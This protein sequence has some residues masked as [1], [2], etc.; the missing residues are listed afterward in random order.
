[1]KRIAVIS[2]TLLHFQQRF[3]DTNK[4]RTCYVEKNEFELLSSLNVLLTDNAKEKSFQCV[5]SFLSPAELFSC[6]C[7]Y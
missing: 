1:M 7:S 5:H 6:G 3:S 4:P 2:Y